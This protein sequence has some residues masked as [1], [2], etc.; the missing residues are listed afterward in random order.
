MTMSY[1]LL[2][3][4]SRA[5]MATR[6]C[7]VVSR[8]SGGARIFHAL[9]ADILPEGDVLGFLGPPLLAGGEKF[10]KAG[11]QAQQVLVGEFRALFEGSQTSSKCRGDW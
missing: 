7:G 9:A 6:A 10:Q 5:D 11:I 4:V 1:W 2:A 3:S 8:K